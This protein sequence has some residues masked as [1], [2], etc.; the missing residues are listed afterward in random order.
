MR[1]TDVKY[2]YLCK[3]ILVGIRDLSLIINLS[4]SITKV[5][6]WISERIDGP[7]QIFAAILKSTE[8]GFLLS[9]TSSLCAAHTWMISLW[10]LSSLVECNSAFSW[11]GNTSIS[12]QWGSWQKVCP[13]SCPIDFTCERP[14]LFSTLRTSSRLETKGRRRKESRLVGASRK[15]GWGKKRRGW[16]KEKDCHHR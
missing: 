9:D 13:S 11:A 4:K 14:T 3:L 15:E 5:K 2:L 6:P 16:E 10:S 12:S 7:E 1:G 8:S